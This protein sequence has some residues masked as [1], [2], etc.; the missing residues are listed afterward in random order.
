MCERS[1][2]V[3]SSIRLVLVLEM[4]LNLHAWVSKEILWYKND[5]YMASL[6]T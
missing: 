3:N 5:S 4:R 2:K 1:A 6:V